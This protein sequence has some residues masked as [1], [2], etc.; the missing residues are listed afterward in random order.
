MSQ[1]QENMDYI[2]II[3]KL[4]E[5]LRPATEYLQHVNQQ[6]D[7]KW[8]HLER[9]LNLREELS[10]FLKFQ[11]ELK[12]T[13]PPMSL[14]DEHE[15]LIVAYKDIVDGTEYMIG[16]LEQELQGH[17]YDFGY[18]IQKTGLSKVKAAATSLM[19]K[20]MENK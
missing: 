5:S 16:S 3:F 4:E 14:R 18:H 12:S 11:R 7:K 1:Q 8:D 15:Q 2:K 13:I 20:V 6:P 19:T 10:S 17:P 9:K